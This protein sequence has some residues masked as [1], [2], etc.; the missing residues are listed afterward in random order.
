MNSQ[1]SYYF[2]WLLLLVCGIVAMC[3][4]FFFLAVKL[5]TLIENNFLLKSTLMLVTYFDSD[6]VIA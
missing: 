4:I 1:L 3:C 2:Y 6:N 5:K